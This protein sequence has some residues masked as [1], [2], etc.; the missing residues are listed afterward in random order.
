MASLT[1]TIATLSTTVTAT[2]AK[3]QAVVG[4]YADAIG[5]SGTDQQRLDLVGEALARHMQEQAQQHRRLSAQAD[6]AAAVE[7]E[8]AALTWE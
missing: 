8:V 7:A 4:G 5:A 6:A 3:A 1:I 2:N